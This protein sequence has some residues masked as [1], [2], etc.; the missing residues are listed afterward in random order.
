M[1]EFFKHLNIAKRFMLGSCAL[2]LPLGVSVYFNTAQLAEKMAFAR[3]EISGNRLQEAP[4]RLI[5]A[6]TD[7]R[8]ASVTVGAAGS[9]KQE[10]ERLMDELAS[11]EKDPGPGLGFTEAGLK[12]EGL[13]SLSASAI[14]REWQDL[15]GVVSSKSKQDGFEALLG[16]LRSRVGHAGDTSNL[17]LDPEMDTYYMADVTSVT[18]A[19]TLARIAAIRCAVARLK[20]D[21]LSPADRIALAV[22]RATLKESD[23]DRI[24]GDI[25]TAIKENGRSVWGVSASLKTNL[26]PA[27]ARYKADTQALID[28]LSAAGDG[29]AVSGAQIGASAVVASRSAQTLWKTSLAELDTLLNRRIDGFA[30]YR[31][32]ILLGTA[33]ALVLGLLALRSTVLGI[34]R[35][36]SDAIAHAGRVAEGN[37]SVRLSDACINRGDEIGTL[38][39]AMQ[40]MSDSLRTM[41]GD[42]SGHVEVLSTS[43]SVLQASSDRMTAE[44]RDA[45]EKAHCVAAAA[46][47]M[48]TNV[49]S[50]A[51][52]MEQAA[53]NLDQ[54]SSATEQMTSTVGEIAVNSERA[55]RITSEANGQ[56]RRVTEQIRHLGEATQQINRIT[57]TITQISSQTNLLALN[58]AI[59]AARAGS[60]GKGFAVVAAEIKTLANETAAATVD[61]KTRI[62]GLQQA[63]AAGIGE[64]EKITGVIHEVSEIVDSI[65]AAI[66]EQ[67]T[68]TKDIA[69]NISE[70]STGMKHATGSFSESSDAS[71]QIARDISMVD[72]AA[73]EMSSATDHVRTSAE[74]VSGIS[75]KLK[76]TVAHFQV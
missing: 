60:A 44:S 45:S 17:T 14:R 57:E 58:A 65:A 23:M 69:R 74:E 71:R 5:A 22:L 33:L 16:D 41:V 48:S 75:N 50:V 53:T 68:A 21:V 64:I 11:A 15:A 66:E 26:E 59:E 6:V 39:R 8:I 3:S 76:L 35:P 27:V 67:S 70:A 25:D 34:T 61:I 37:L 73:L 47:Q 20:G 55:R 46:E 1:K 29:K 49:V 31:M 19:Q 24:T 36:L 12:A 9:E 63:S 10:T 30:R 28:L 4:V 43:A 42:M 51:G 54:V 32:E 7:Y 72:H 56:A 52:G 13:S 2:L 40:E 62:A 38:S 18:T